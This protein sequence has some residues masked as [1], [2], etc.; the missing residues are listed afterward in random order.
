MAKSDGIAAGKKR[1]LITVRADQWDAL[2]AKL[3]ESGYP[4]G[5][6]SYYLSSCLDSLDDFLTYGKDSAQM[7]LFELRE[8]QQLRK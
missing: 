8:L 1:V 7:P 2:Q 3:K 4:H 6:M 5:S